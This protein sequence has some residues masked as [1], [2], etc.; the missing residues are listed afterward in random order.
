[1]TNAA[2]TIKPLNEGAW[3]KVQKLEKALDT[4]TMYPDSP[5]RRASE[6]IIRNALTLLRRDM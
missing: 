3:A 1:M 6:N 5:A 2:A 4:L